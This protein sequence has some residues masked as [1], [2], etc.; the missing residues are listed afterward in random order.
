MKQ[1]NTL[2]I[3]KKSLM[4]LTIFGVLGA[5]KIVFLVSII[6]CGDNRYELAQDKNGRTIRLDK[7]TGEVAILEGD[8]LIVARTPEEKQSNE[9]NAL[10]RMTAF[11]KPKTWPVLE[12]KQF[13]VE[14]AKL[15]TSWKD[16]RLR[17]R[18][19]LRPVPKNFEKSTFLSPLLTL[20]L[21]DSSDFKV[22]SV[23]LYRT[24]LTIGVDENGNALGLSA[25]SSTPCSQEEY[26]TIAVWNLLWH[27]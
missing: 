24:D 5:F 22:I 4:S 13:G 23:D 11:R 25:N 14:Q 15:I 27:M 16:G 3:R 10:A 6:S 19:E 8:S 12:F 20:V 2:Y 18:L 26:E 7:R 21:Y 17:Y 9:E 1:Q